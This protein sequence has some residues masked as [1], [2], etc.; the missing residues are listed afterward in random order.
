MS[1]VV[2]DDTTLRDGEQTPGV[3]FTT[4]D[5][6][7]IAKLLDEMGVGEIEAGFPASGEYAMRQ[8]EAISALNLNA[9]L[10]AWNRALI[11]DIEKSISAGA[12]CVEISLPVSDIQM[13][14]KIKKSKKWVIEQLKKV[15]TYCKEKGLYLSVGGEDSSRA[16]PGFLIE[17]IRTAEKY[18][19]DRFRFCDTVGVLNPFTT[20]NLI[21]EL[22]S[23]TSLPF[24]IHAHN[25]LGMATANALASVK[26]GVTHI[27]TTLLG[28]GERAGN[29]P[30]EEIYFAL[31]ISEGIDLKIDTVKM[32]KLA[33]L[34][35]KITKFKINKNK[36]IFGENIFTHESGI[37]VDGVLKNSSNYEP[38]SPELIGVKRKFTFGPTS[39]KAALKQVLKNKDLTTE[40]DDN[41]LNKIKSML[42]SY[43]KS[44][45]HFNILENIVK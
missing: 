26:A 42:I 6:I 33:M 43:P 23:E 13:N 45:K 15:V 44:I 27:N 29:T 11:S 10:I 19:A 9:R 5:K 16:E 39:G 30:L 3:I 7:S 41:I 20:Y 24:E 12:K 1:K 17:Y 38:F 36:P 37:H 14:T 2:I 32:R 22:K 25:D 31:K 21:K 8:F 4:K 40:I 18:G 28:L 34:I 35:S